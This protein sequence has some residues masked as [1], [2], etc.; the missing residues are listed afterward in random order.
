[1]LL[2]RRLRLLA[3]G[4]AV[5]IGQTEGPP[6][7]PPLPAAERVAVHR[8]GGEAQLHQSYRQKQGQEAAYLA[9]RVQRRHRGGGE[10][11]QRVAVR[12]LEGPEDNTRQKRYGSRDDHE[13]RGRHQ[14]TVQGPTLPHEYVH[15][16]AKGRDHLDGGFSFHLE[17][18]EARQMKGGDTVCV[19]GCERVGV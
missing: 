6:E 17:Q 12:P 13:S 16:V 9:S 7:A 1:M 2:A 14:A 18:C 11:R 4:R 3:L 19:C 10:K 15:P 8:A 5:K